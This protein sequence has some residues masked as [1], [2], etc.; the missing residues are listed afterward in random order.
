MV[1]LEKFKQ[2]KQNRQLRTQ[3]YFSEDFKRKK[4]REIEQNLT[5]VTQL[6][7]EYE[8]SNT[9]IYRWIHK[10]SINMKKGVVQIVEAKSDTV[11]IQKLKDQIKELERIVGQK[12]IIIDFQQK[13][14]ELAENE[15]G[16]EIKKKYVSKP[17]P[18]SGLTETNTP[19]K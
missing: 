9:S 5:T 14:I 11:K 17:L 18:G 19:T 3:R 15:L 13:M 2:H 8:V 16:V 10:Y 7:K 6:C 1:N 12:Q 4:V